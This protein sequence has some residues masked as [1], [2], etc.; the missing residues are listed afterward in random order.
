[1][2]SQLIFLVQMRK[3]AAECI[4]FY[5]WPKIYDKMPQFA[6]NFTKKIRKKNLIHFSWNWFHKKKWKTIN[7]KI[8]ETIASESKIFPAVAGFI[9]TIFLKK[10]KTYKPMMISQTIFFQNLKCEP[11]GWTDPKDGTL[12]GINCYFIICICRVLSLTLLFYRIPWPPHDAAFCSLL[13]CFF[14]QLFWS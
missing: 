13:C 8:L 14:S 9:L 3:S 12:I 6:L 4:F 7:Q 2:R 5:I 11:A 1:M 10:R